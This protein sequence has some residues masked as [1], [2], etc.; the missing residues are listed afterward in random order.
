MDYSKCAISGETEV[1]AV[2]GDPIGHTLSPAIQNAAFHSAQINAV[3]VPFRVRK[4]DLKDAVRGMRALG[5]KGFNV[6]I[7]HKVEIIRQLDRI[8]HAAEDIGSVNTVLNNDGLLCG[9]NTDGLGALKSLE[10]A[11]ARLND[12]SILLFGAGGASRAIAHSIA[13]H[14]RTIKIANRTVSKAKQLQRRLQRTFKTLDVAAV[15][16]SSESIRD[17]VQEADIIANASSMGHD[18]L[19]DPPIEQS[20]LHPSQFVLDIVYK[21]IKTKLLTIAQEAG[22]TT[23]NGLQMLVNQGACSFEIWTGKKAPIDAM[24]DAIREKL[25]V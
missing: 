23:I 18:G 8:D 10:A 13:K 16:L 21:P 17:F 9:Y 11:G 15:G 14:A 3:Y 7:P 19:V 6:T 25:L 22:A 5:V 2:I 1:Y 24:H 12:Q 20:C 4:P